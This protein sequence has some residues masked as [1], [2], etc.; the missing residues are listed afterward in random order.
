M[1]GLLAPVGGLGLQGRGGFLEDQVKH[2][3]AGPGAEGLDAGAD[4]LLFGLG[5][6]QRLGEER[7]V[8]DAIG[9]QPLPE[10]FERV[11]AGAVALLVEGAV[12][13]RIIGRWSAGRGGRSWP[14]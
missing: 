14:R 9:Q 1:F 3:G 11:G 12:A 4:L 13:A 2:F 10:P 5:R 7:L 6:G 8:G